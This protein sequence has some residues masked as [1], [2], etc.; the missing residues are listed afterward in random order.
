M[1]AAFLDASSV[2]FPIVLNRSIACDDCG[3]ELEI[4]ASAHLGMRSQTR[5]WTCLCPSCAALPR[6]RTE[7]ALPEATHGFAT[8]KRVVQTVGVAIRAAF[9][10]VRGLFRREPRPG[11]VAVRR[12]FEELGTTYVKLGQLVASSEGLFPEPYCRELQSCLD[13]VPPFGFRDVLRTIE[14]ELGKKPAELFADIDERPLASASIAQV[15]AARLRSGEEVVI[16]VQRPGLSPVLAADLSILRFVAKGLAARRDV[17]M[18]DPIGIVDDFAAN[19]A[20][21]LDFT[22]EAA[23][24]AEF[25]RIMVARGHED[26]AA[27]RTS[28]VARRAMVMER[29]HGHRVDDVER[30]KQGTVDAEAKLLTG[31]RA[32]FRCLVFHG[33]FHGD[34]HA[35]NLMALD[36]GRI[37]FLDFGIVGRFD[38][39][40]RRQVTDY[41]LAFA[42]SDFERVAEVMVEMGSAPRKVDRRALAA[43]MRSSFEPILA[44]GAKYADLLPAMMAAGT[45]HGLRLP[46]EMVLVT[47]QMIYFDRYA[48]ILAPDLN[49]FRDPRVVSGLAEDVMA[50]RALA[51]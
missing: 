19:L 8:A 51:I 24:M 45:R 42:V 41:L 4:G 43:D 1:A 34:V 15:H 29:F 17:G 25:N 18:A 39:A 33:F 22:R 14:H 30:M 47:K 3:E 11:P 37:G 38:E 44:A 36:D 10:W 27:P 31:M 13:R 16:K 20:E 12:A 50:A 7:L 28:L 35:G 40:R 5:G 2:F 26:V 9:R 46:R 6:T 21:E 32:W 48:K 23:N 49:V